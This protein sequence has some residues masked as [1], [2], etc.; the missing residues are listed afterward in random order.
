MRL[1]AKANQSITKSGY[2]VLNIIAIDLQLYKIFKIILISFFGTHCSFHQYIWLKTWTGRRHGLQQAASS[3]TGRDRT[4]AA[5]HKPSLKYNLS[6]KKP[7]P[8]NQYDLIHQF[9][10]FTNKKL[11]CRRETARR[12][13][14]LNI[15]LSHSRSLK[16]IQNDTV[17]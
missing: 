9:T 17:D 15:S 16:I 7:Q 8:C 14:S 13:V 11:S 4:E 12:F 1:I 10:T 5:C 6:Q 2:H 3:F